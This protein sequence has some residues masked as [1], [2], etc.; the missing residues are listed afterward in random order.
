MGELS[1]G[2]IFQVPLIENAQLKVMFVGQFLGGANCRDAPV[3][4][5]SSP[6]RGEMWSISTSL[7]F[8]D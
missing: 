1:L 5:P 7:I 4:Q 2:Q 6:L 3:R 8:I